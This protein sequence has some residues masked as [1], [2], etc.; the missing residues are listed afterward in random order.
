MSK[1]L[2]TG[3]WHIKGSNPRNRIGMYKQQQQDKIRWILNLADKEN[4]SCILQPGD[5]FDNRQMPEEI[6]TD[7]IYLFKNSDIPIF[8]VYG[9]HDMQY[10]KNKRN[11]AMAVL[12]AADAIKV[13]NQTPIEVEGNIHIYGASWGEEIPDVINKD[14]LN[15]L[16]IHTMVIEERPLWPGQK[17]FTKKNLLMK[18]NNDY[19]IFCCGDNH[20]T[21]YDGNGRQQVFNLGSLMRS[22]IAQL[23]HKPTIAIYDIDEGSTTF[24]KI[25]IEPA[26]IVFD[27]E[28]IDKEADKA[29]FT[30]FFNL[31]SSEA[32][33]TGVDFETNVKILSD[34]AKCTKEEQDITRNYIAKYYQSKEEQL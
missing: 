7:Y 6:K 1:L 25:P 26:E 2:L 24:F 30:E 34:K 3:D 27:V 10:H 18:G 33:D 4:C 17:R 22:T 29:D 12:E 31:L 16:V 28:K 9:Q 32:K 5:L 8:T 13:L 19:D 20:N 14:H 21:F 15:I 11:S 23:A